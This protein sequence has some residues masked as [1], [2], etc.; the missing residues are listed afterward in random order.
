MAGRV[1][2][3]FGLDH[4]IPLPYRVQPEPS[5]TELAI[6]DELKNPETGA[7]AKIHL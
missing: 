2:G 3:S 7:M 1:A 5:D 6:I 4:N